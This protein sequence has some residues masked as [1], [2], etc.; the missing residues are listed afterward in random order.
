MEAHRGLRVFPG[1]TPRRTDWIQLCRTP[2]DPILL[3]RFQVANYDEMVA[4]LSQALVANGSSLVVISADVNAPAAT[5]VP[6]PAE[7]VA[8]PGVLPGSG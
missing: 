2:G 1:G 5:R 8:Q 3:P 6:P 7:P 4:S